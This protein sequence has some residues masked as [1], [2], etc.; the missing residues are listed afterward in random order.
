MGILLVG[1]VSAIRVADLG[2]EVVLLADHVVADTLSV[3]VLEVSV[4]VDLDDA[5]A[6]GVE[7]LL[8]A[9]ARA[10]VEDEE[11]GLAVL[12]AGLLLDVLL[13][14][15]QK[16]GVKPDVA[17][18]VDTMDV[19]EGGGNGEVGRDLGEGLED[20]V[21][22]LGLG[23][24]GVVVDILVVDTVLLTTSDTNLLCMCQ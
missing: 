22:V 20:L 21:D 4:E 7:V 6:D 23:V 11:D 18:L 17:G 10:T 1:L 9:G 14:L 2:A 19:A 13:V 8:L 12:A 16:F 15:A 3:G 5:I 24:K